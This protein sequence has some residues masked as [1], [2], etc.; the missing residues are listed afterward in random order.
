M[1]QLL[2][3][4]SCSTRYDV[5]HRAP[6]ERVRCAR[7]D[8]EL[9]V[10][11][12]G[13]GTVRDSARLR[14]AKGP[15]CQNHPRA[16]ARAR[17]EGCGAFVCAACTAP[18]PGD[19]FCQPC[20]H[21]RGVNGAIPV[22]F[23]LLAAWSAALGALLRV[24]PRVL[25]WNLL[26]FAGSALL[27]SIPLVYG[28]KVLEVISFAPTRS[29]GQGD[30]LALASLVVG[31]SGV[32]LTY[33]LLLVPAGCCLFVD[34]QLRGRKVPFRA[35]LSEAW[36]RFKQTGVA[37]FSVAVILIGLFYLPYAVL[38]GGVGYGLRQLF[39]EG[40]LQ[41]WLVVSAVVGIVPLWLAGG[42]A[43]PVVVLEQRGAMDSLRRAWRLMRGR[44][45][46]VAALALS[47]GLVLAVGTSAL[48]YLGKLSGHPDAFMPLGHVFDV[49]WPAVLTAA[50]HGLASEDAE[51][52]GREN[53]YAEFHGA[54]EHLIA[55]Q[56]A[57]SEA[58]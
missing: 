6:G 37:L 55:Q 23:G 42:F 52:P 27:F 9:V 34:M 33:Y 32:F 44:L 36:T 13:D 48:A 51:I 45:G 15:V 7:C 28:W 58:G 53:P 39:G 41:V 26:A 11:Q 35:A 54:R 5:R 17:C 38:I 8:A 30:D 12:P 16:R 10:P 1:S 47:Y 18:R 29:W 3:C 56:I 43:L 50:Y 21:E 2:T 20:A 49:A 14:L 25:V 19:H 24:F 4:S 57:E 46:T 31:V 40:P 22:D